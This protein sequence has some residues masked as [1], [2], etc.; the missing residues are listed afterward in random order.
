MKNRLVTAGAIAFNPA[1]GLSE[2]E[3]TEL[4][5]VLCT[6]SDSAI[7]RE[8]IEDQIEAMVPAVIELRDRFGVEL[9]M[10]VLGEFG[11]LAGFGQLADDVR[12]S[13]RARQRCKAIHT[14]LVVMGVKAILGHTN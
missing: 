9:N 14:R 5:R 3:L 7:D 8:E 1:A 2:Y 10:K 4:L 13:S 11:T 12:L 6:Q